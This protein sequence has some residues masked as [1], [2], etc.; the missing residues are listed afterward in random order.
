MKYLDTCENTNV[1]LHILILKR[2]SCKDYAMRTF[3]GFNP[4]MPGGNKGRTYLNKSATKSCRF[5]QV[6]MAFCFLLLLPGIK[7]LRIIFSF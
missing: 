3:Y 2:Y 7:G 5:V 6:R 1:S 4:L